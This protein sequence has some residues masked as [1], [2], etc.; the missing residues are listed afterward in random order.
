MNDARVV[1]VRLP[2]PAGDVVQS[3]PALLDGLAERDDVLPVEDAAD[4]GVGAPLRL[5]RRLR[6]A[7]A[8]VVVV[9]PG[10]FSSAL[11]ARASGARV[12]VGV[13]GRGRRLL[14]A[15]TLPRRA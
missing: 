3:T 13:A 1:V 14:L 8:D 9:M 4:R 7:G 12:R 6:E 2:N 15:R 10:S 5:G 11:A